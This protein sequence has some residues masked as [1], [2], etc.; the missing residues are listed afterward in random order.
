MQGACHKRGGVINKTAPLQVIKVI[1]Y[2]LDWDVGNP[3]AEVESRVMTHIR[4]MGFLRPVMRGVSENDFY[5]IPAR[6]A[7]CP[8]E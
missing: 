5:G 4:P 3:F 2:P 6:G 1:R 8:V 7:A